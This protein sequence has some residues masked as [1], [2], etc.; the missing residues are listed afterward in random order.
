MSDLISRQAAIEAIG[1]LCSCTLDEE[2]IWR[3]IIGRIP[4]AQQE[5]I[6]CRDCRWWNKYSDT[7]GYCMAAK[8]GYWSEHWDITIK[9]TY[10][11]DWYCADAE[12]G[13]GS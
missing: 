12:R 6:R 8:H 11:A 3:E 2:A 13:E 4:S 5:I 9:R 7:H 1:E 10:D